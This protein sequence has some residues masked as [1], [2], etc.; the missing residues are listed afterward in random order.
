[1]LHINRV[2]LRTE[3][4]D[5]SPRINGLTGTYIYMNVKKNVLFLSIVVILGK[6]LIRQ[7]SAP[8][9]TEFD[10]QLSKLSNTFRLHY[11]LG[12]WYYTLLTNCSIRTSRIF[13]TCYQVQL[14]T[15]LSRMHHQ[16][17]FILFFS[18][19]S[20]SSHIFYSLSFPLVPQI[21]GHIAGSSPPS[22]LRYVP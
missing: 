10:I 12:I 13:Y 9:S 22:P 1:M 3:G 8:R 5:A 15:S 6:Y 20:F 2:R 21:R 19:H 14:C 18:S 16:M 7:L 11:I 4:N 17:F